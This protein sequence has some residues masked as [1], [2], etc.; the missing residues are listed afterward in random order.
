[1]ITVAITGA[2][3]NLGKVAVKRLMEQK[4]LRVRALLHGTKQGKAFAAALRR[5]YG[6]R[7]EILYGDICDYRACVLLT[8]GVD[9]VLH[10]AAVI[11]PK[12]D[13]QR[14]LAVA[15][16]R[17]GTRN[18]VDAVIENG[19]RAG[20]LFIST[21]AIYGNRNEKHPWGRVGDPLLTSAFDVYGRSK[22]EAE[23]Y[24][25]DS[26]LNRWAI[27]R[28]SA[29]L[30]DNILTGNIS[31]GL[32]FHTP[33]NALIE[34]VT[35]EDSGV[36]FSNIIRRDRCGEIGVFWKKIYNVGGG[37]SARQTGYETFDD[38]FRLIG[39][40]VKRFFRPNWNPPRNFHCFWFSDSDLLEKMF[41]FRSQGTADFWRKYK[42][43][44]W[45]YSVGGIVPSS[46]L[47]KLVIERLMKNANAPAYWREH[48]DTA[49]MQAFFGPNDAFEKLPSRWEDFPLLC[50]SKNYEA[51]KQ[52]DPRLDLKHGYDES[53]P[54]TLLDISDMQEAAA[55]R[56]G[57][58][59]SEGMIP[60]DL[61]RK[62]RWRC[63]EG[64]EFEASPY[65]VLKAGHWCAACCGEDMEWH[66]DR[67]ARHSPFHAQV[68]KDF[69][70]PDEC[71]LY[72]IRNGKAEMRPEK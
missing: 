19:N 1:M 71:Y 36:L 66:T 37:P 18:L 52:H 57:V 22:T 28:Q 56:G 68:W 5:K 40:S 30:Y 49:R 51:L 53:K 14:E 26:A 45:I 4:D 41:H 60:G 6:A 25:L 55:F 17:D 61:Y 35:A 13:H 47:R 3:G 8:D 34:W 63:H 7:V 67:I 69:H 24:I 29:V 54:D 2:R 43:K 16:N 33:W 32:M 42:K 12:A 39:G 50:E 21:V 15:S 64:H 48:G 10:L 44:H 58:C 46:L 38:G 31:D 70:E 72:S 20:F 11:P 9:Y 27:L 62:L 59:L 65:T 23:R